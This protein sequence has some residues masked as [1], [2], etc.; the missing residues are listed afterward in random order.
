MAGESAHQEYDRKRSRRQER[1]RR[2]WPAIV[3]LIAVS[4]AFGRAVP[5]VLISRIASV[6]TSVGQE[7]TAVTVSVPPVI[8]SVVF[9]IAL[10]GRTA[11]ELLAPSRSE[12]AWGKGAEGERIVGR[13]L[14]TLAGDA[15][16]DYGHAQV[17]EAVHR[18][19]HVVDGV[20]PQDEF[21]DDLPLVQPAGAADSPNRLPSR[22][23]R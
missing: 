13:A 8:V 9:A 1:I 20:E 18:L 17:F 14:D 11:S 10:A 4:F 3:A 19:C 22:C 16:G 21:G 6:A 5:I 15:G 7:G 12:A 2:S 23:G